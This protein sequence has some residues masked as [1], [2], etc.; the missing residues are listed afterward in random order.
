MTTRFPAGRYWNHEGL[1]TNNP[2][3]TTNQHCVH[4]HGNCGNGG[5]CTCNVES[6]AIQCAG[7]SNKVIK[8]AYGGYYYSL[9]PIRYIRNGV[10]QNVRPGDVIRTSNHWL[11]V[12]EAGE[13]TT[14]KCTD[15]NW[16]GTNDASKR[17]IIRW[18]ATKKGTVDRVYCSPY[19]WS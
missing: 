14:A 16:G 4:A 11:V 7:Y 3:G 18:G 8:D 17:C 9:W 15:C 12:C 10:S 19:T 6:G 1:S 13:L 2:G 5:H